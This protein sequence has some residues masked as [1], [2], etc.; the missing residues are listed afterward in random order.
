MTSY[1]TQDKPTVQTVTQR[2]DP[3]RTSTSGRGAT[4]PLSGSPQPQ[5]L[6]TASDTSLLPHLLPQAVNN[7][8]YL[9]QLS[10]IASHKPS[11]Y[12]LESFRFKLWFLGLPQGIEN[13]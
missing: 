9:D 2:S 10:G 3:T 5:G 7:H 11:F 4:R 13:R 1:N 12:R 8:S 6:C